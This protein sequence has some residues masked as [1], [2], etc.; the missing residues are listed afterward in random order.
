MYKMIQTMLILILILNWKSHYSLFGFQEFKF[1]EESAMLNFRL[2]DGENE[3][4][5]IEVAN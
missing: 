3:G 5:L 4:S 1:V 2:R